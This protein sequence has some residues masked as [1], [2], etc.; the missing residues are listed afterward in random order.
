MLSS[1][2]LGEIA[3]FSF[4]NASRPGFYNQRSKENGKSIGSAKAFQNNVLESSI[5]TRASRN[6]WRRLRM[7][8]LLRLLTAC[9]VIFRSPAILSCDTQ[10]QNSWRTSHWSANGSFSNAH[11]NESSGGQTFG[12]PVRGAVPS[13]HAVPS[14]CTKWRSVRP[15]LPIPSQRASQNPLIQERA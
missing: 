9:C 15:F 12:R 1:G 10:F 7:T 3:R 2:K 4:R 5:A 13:S 6:K 11:C 8:L 14:S